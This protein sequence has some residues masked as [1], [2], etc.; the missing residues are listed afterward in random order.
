MIK[1]TGTR[2]SRS[3]FF[4]AKSSWMP[5]SRTESALLASAPLIDKIIQV[6]EMF[7]SLMN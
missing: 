5:T 6:C 3:P 7:F 4:I 1:A 2:T